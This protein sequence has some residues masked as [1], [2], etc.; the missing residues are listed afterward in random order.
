[1]VTATSRRMGPTTQPQGKSGCLPV[2][3]VV[4][5]ADGADVDIAVAVGKG[6]AVGHGVAVVARVEVGRG[7]AAGTGVGRYGRYEGSLK[8]FIR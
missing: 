5:T 6:V 1:M 8:R 4:G 7:V 3:A 2:T